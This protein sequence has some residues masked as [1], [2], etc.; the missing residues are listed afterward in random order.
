[1]ADHEQPQPARRADQAEPGARAGR[2]RRID[3]IVQRERLRR[4]RRRRRR[5]PRQRRRRDHRAP[6]GSCRSR[7]RSACSTPVSRRSAPPL[8][9]GK[10]EDWSFQK[11]VNDVSIGGVPV[12]KQSALIGNFTA[13]GLERPDRL[14][15]AGRHV[16]DGVPDAGRRGRATA[17]GLEPQPRRG[18]S[19]PN[20]ALLKY[21]GDAPTRTGFGV[22]LQRL[23][24]LP[25]RRLRRRPRRLTGPN[26]PGRAARRIRR[27]L[28]CGTTTAAP[29]WR[30]TL[31]ARRGLTR[32]VP[33]GPG[34][35][36]TH[37]DHIVDLGGDPAMTS[38]LDARRD[39]RVADL[40]LAPFG[41]KEMHPRRTR[42][43]RPDGDPQGV[44]ADQAARRRPHLRVAAHDDPD[45]GA[46][47]D[48]Q[49]AR[50]RGALGELQ[51]LLDPGS[52]RG[53]GRGRPRRH[54]RR[55]AGRA[56]VRLEGRDARGVLVVHRAD[57]VVAARATATTART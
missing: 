38:T 30:R 40:S 9:P 47:R 54:R 35:L 27:V 46:D 23:R 12:G 53:R 32:S 44:R 24:P 7:R 25:G 21:G 18:R 5:L 28:G 34:S 3:P 33:A 55:S 13:A 8:A 41:R 45:R 48:A 16:H 15:H 43:A 39:F 2:R 37:A 4:S 19:V 29:T 10:A 6:G 36:L 57:D 49:R 26:S 14:V 11:F 17:G 56:G 22:Q 42:D 1:M 51:H 31:G 52:R 20:M 50:R